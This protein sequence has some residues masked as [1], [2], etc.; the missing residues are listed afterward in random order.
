MDVAA[1][2]LKDAQDH[3]AAAA[4]LIGL[5]TFPEE[6]WKAVIFSAIGAEKLLKHLLCRINPCL[7]LK[8]VDFENTVMT[9]HAD[10]V[11]N[12]GKLADLK[13]KAS[14]DVVTFKISV[15]RAAHFS[16][17]VGQYAPFLH[18]LAD[19]RD[20]AAHRPWAEVNEDHARIALCRDL[21]VAIE[22]IAG[23]IST[24]VIHLWGSHRSRL[25]A[26]S[27]AM[28]EKL[29][30]SLQMA[31]LLKRHRDGWIE[32]SKDPAVVSAAERTTHNRLAKEPYVEECK[33]PACGGIA[34][35]ILKPDVEYSHDKNAEVP[36]VHV[37]GASIVAIQCSFCLLRLEK[38]DQL[39]HVNASALL[40][41]T[42]DLTVP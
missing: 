19:L 20:M 29:D 16:A 17:A 11:I 14:P 24:D 39:Q 40:A 32:R 41:R 10:K 22:A 9:W 7:A 26:L 5:D 36:V 34:L 8:A 27:A 37:V 3:F 21:Y 31:R 35:A 28:A 23:S 15:Q 30:V 4:P 1:Q 33:C 25:Q 42:D 12:P 13:K 6:Q 38:Y 2:Y 18:W